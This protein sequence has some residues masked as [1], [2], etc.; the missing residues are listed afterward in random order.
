MT[1]SDVARIKYELVEEVAR[2]G[3]D[4]RGGYIRYAAF[5]IVPSSG[6]NHH[7]TAQKW[8]PLSVEQWADIISTGD[9]NAL[10]LARELTEL[11]RAA[12]YKAFFFET[13][14]ASPLTA[15]TKQFEFVLVNSPDLY[16]FCESRPDPHAFSEHLNCLPRDATACSFRNLG[17]D[18][19]LI[20]PRPAE[21]NNDVKV[22]TH[23][24]AF[25]RGASMKQITDLWKFAAT[26]Y[27]KRLDSSTNGNRE[28]VWFS[29]SGLG[30]AWLHL[31]LDSQPKY[32]Q[33]R[34]FARE[35]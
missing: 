12:P 15:P 34:P 4:G 5:G 31:R 22:Y 35:K 13:K 20:A 26:E 3:K 25:L 19:V 2:D 29:T 33:Y 23:L 24:A 6:G 17:G 30:I 32:Y 21:N 7:D 18:A 28:T 8:M 9:D 10:A 14:G 1:S 11:I 16:R 27:Q